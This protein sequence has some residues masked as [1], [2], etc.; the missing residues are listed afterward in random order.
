VQADRRKKWCG[1]SLVAVV[2][3]SLVLTA[4]A[5]TGSGDVAAVGSSVPAASST[6]D[7]LAD[8]SA[9]QVAGDASATLLV[10]GDLGDCAPGGDRG[11]ASAALA[12][13]LTGP[14]LLLG[15]IAYPDGSSA[16][17]RECFWPAWKPLRDRA[18]AVIGNHDDR[19]RAAFYRKWPN[20]GTSSRPWYR[21]RVGEWRVLVVDANCRVVGCGS[22]SPQ[23]TWLRA[24]LAS[25]DRCTVLAMHQPRFSSDDEHGDSLTVDTLW[26]T[27]HRGGVDL[28]VAG[29][30]HDYERIGPVSLTGKANDHGPVL[31]V[32]GTGGAAPRSFATVTPASAK[33]IAGQFGLARLTLEPQAWSAEFLAAP[34]GAVR[35]TASGGCR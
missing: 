18:H 29:H 25:N 17:Y 8:G 34:G 13:T 6:A 24:R 27:A 35:D 22:T 28:V 21:F 3:G 5:S 4:C 12:S 26:R 31:F 10:V 2:A 19:H 30:A 16:D 9:P 14:I 20:S 15:D 11:E 32:V 33:R 23:V 7:T 1:V